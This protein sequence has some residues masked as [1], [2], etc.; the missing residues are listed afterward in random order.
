MAKFKHLT[1]S[2]VDHVIGRIR[3]VESSLSGLATL[4]YGLDMHYAPNY[5][6][7]NKTGNSLNAVPTTISDGQTSGLIV[8]IQLPKYF[9]SP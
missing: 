6:Q 8:L 4:F 2:K 9:H 7:E 1:K 3:E 5:L